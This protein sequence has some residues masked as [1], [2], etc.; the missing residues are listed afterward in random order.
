MDFGMW[1]KMEVASKLCRILTKASL[2]A[3]EMMMAEA[4]QV[5][6]FWT[7]IGLLDGSLYIYYFA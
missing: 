6:N 2:K 7:Q 5:D 4:H 1:M 3:T